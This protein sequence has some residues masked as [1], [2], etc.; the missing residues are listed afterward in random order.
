MPN[1]P[2]EIHIRNQ[3]NLARMVEATT[4]AVAL[5]LEQAISKALEVVRTMRPPLS[6]LDLRVRQIRINEIFDAAA[7]DSYTLLI[8]RSIKDAPS[9]LKQSEREVSAALAQAQ[10]EVEAEAEQLDQQAADSERLFPL[11]LEQTIAATA[12]MGALE[13]TVMAQRP[14]YSLEQGMARAFLFPDGTVLHDAINVPPDQLQTL[15]ERR[16]RSAIV[17][18][19]DP[20]DLARQ[21]ESETGRSVAHHRT[22]ARTGS[23]SIAAAVNELALHE[24]SVE[25]VQFTAVLD[26]RTSDLCRGLDGRVYRLEEAPHPPLHRNCV[27]GDTL[28]TPCGRVAAVHRRRYEGLLYILRTANGGEAKMTPNHPVLTNRGWQ[29]AQDLKLGDRVFQPVAQRKEGGIPE[30]QQVMTAEDFATAFRELPGVVTVS[31]PVTPKDFHGDGQGT[32]TRRLD[33]EVGV[34]SVNRSLAIELDSPLLQL[35]SNPIF[36]RAA[37]LVPLL[38]TAKERGDGVFSAPASAVGGLGKSLAFSRVSVGHASELLLRA[39]TKRDPLFGQDSIYGTF[40][41]AE[42]FR[43]APDP[44]SA[45]VETDNLGDLVRGENATAAKADIRLWELG[46]DAGLLQPSFAAANGPGASRGGLALSPKGFEQV[47]LVGIE[48]REFHGDVFNFET[49]LASFVAGS[50]LTHNCRSSLRPYL[51]DRSANRAPTP[52][53]W[54]QGQDQATQVGLLGEAGA[55]AFRASGRLA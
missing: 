8:D 22:N 26:G 33:Q 20:A 16:M 48:V 42:L 37:Q 2:D 15:F 38:C 44:D 46:K 19:Q 29:A 41:D 7:Q 35:I 24:A 30:N 1:S 28:I 13:L 25:M 9:W 49:E 6:V 39:T 14:G 3:L 51:G 23:Y 43:D 40:A 5:V 54:L 17:N 47:E 31:V 32:C 36:A 34:V 12:A 18:G 11:T 4:A 21:L 45:L 52:V 27:P 53:D 50:I 55:G 10:R